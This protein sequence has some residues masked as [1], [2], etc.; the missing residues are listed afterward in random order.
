MPAG[1]VAR[2][3]D[4]ECTHWHSA[5]GLELKPLSGVRAMSRHTIDGRTFETRD[6]KKVFPENAWIDV[7]GDRQFFISCAT[8]SQWEH[9][10]LYLSCK[11]QWY[12]VHSS[13]WPGS[14][15]T[16][17]CVGCNEAAQWMTTNRYALIDMP[18]ELRIFATANCE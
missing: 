5:S 1:T 7:R 18:E 6:A 9:E 13:Q 2:F 14:Y 3:D 17:R 16:A 11:E 15:E 12:I 8:Q 4:V 10:T